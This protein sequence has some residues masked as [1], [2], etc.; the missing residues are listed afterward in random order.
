MIYSIDMIKDDLRNLTEKQFYTKHIIRSDNWYFEKYL[1]KNPDEVIHLLD[2]YRLIVSESFG[3]SFNSVMMVGSGK[4][5]F[6]MSPPVTDYPHN[7]KMFLPFNDDEKVRKVSDLDIAIISNDIFH[8]YWKI[9]RKS[10]KSKFR[11]TY[12][13]LY[14]ELYRGYINERNILEVDGC[15][16]QWNETATVSKKKL[17]SDL[18]FKHEVSYRIY[19]NWEDFEE[20]NIQ[21]IRK[22]KKEVI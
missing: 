3:V 6:S 15:R 12:L 20:Y 10:Y 1:Q 13:H 14:N 22:I 19:R 21:N 11:N 8:Q 4:L 9:F 5:G 2:D 18:Y 17:K 16:K 7:S